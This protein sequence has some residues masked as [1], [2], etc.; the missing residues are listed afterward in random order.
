MI[1][2]PIADMLVRIK[3]ANQRKHKDVSMENSKLKVEIAKILK[4]EGYIINYEIRKIDKVK[5]DLVIILKYKEEIRVIT[6]LKKISKPGLRVYSESKNVPKVLNGFGISIISTSK[7]MM[8]G[9]EARN[10]SL[11]G[12]VIAYVW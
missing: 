1:S 6:G 2:D 4:S 12:E 3:N 5:S 7:G 8:T 10:K 11:G 9:K